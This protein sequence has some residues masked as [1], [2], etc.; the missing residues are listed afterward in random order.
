LFFVRRVSTGPVFARFFILINMN[1]QLDESAKK[2]LELIRKNR[3][4]PYLTIVEDG[5]CQ[6]SNVFVRLDE[7]DANFVKLKD[8]GGY[9][10]YIRNNILPFYKSLKINIHALERVDDSFSAETEFGYKLT[11]SYSQSNTQETSKLRNMYK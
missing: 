9:R 10:I 2:V 3:G 4:E 5:C 7:P 1:V 6:F 8:E 11:I